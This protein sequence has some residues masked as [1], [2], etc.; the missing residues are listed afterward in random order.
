MN[1]QQCARQQC[2][3]V[4]SLRGGFVSGRGGGLGTSNQHNSKGERQTNDH[5]H[6][7]FRA[8]RIKTAKKTPKKSTWG[9]RWK[10]VAPGRVSAVYLTPW[11]PRRARSDASSGAGLAEQTAHLEPG[12]IEKQ[13]SMVA[14]CDCGNQAFSR[15]LVSRWQADSSTPW[16]TPARYTALAAPRDARPSQS[17]EVDSLSTA[18]FVLFIRNQM[19]KKILPR[20]LWLILQR[21]PVHSWDFK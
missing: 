1:L 11:T 5:S 14:N 8:R 10:S 2:I 19:E 15:H 21:S 20:I 6:A 9:R 4:T 17:W 13:R 7:Q 16:E 12:P 18:C 3:S